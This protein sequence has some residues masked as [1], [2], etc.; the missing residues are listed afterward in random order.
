M[1]AWFYI[2][3]LALFFCACAPAFK[4]KGVQ[5]IDGA[6]LQQYHTYDFYQITAQGDTSHISFNIRSDVMKNAVISEMNKRGFKKVTANP[7]LLINIGIVS[8][9]QIQNKTSNFNQSG[10]YYLGQP[11]Y[12]WKTSDQEIGRYK[13]GTATMRLVDAKQNKLVWQGSVQGIVPDRELQLED[14]I[15]Q[16]IVKL[17]TKF[18]VQAK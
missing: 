6:D 4:T 10:P 12:Q 18:P 9:N 17:F 7:D 11:N 13:D 8:K 14:A 1:K 5:L 15:K 16:A 2:S 3:F